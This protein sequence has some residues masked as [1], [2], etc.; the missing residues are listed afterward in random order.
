MADINNTISSSAGWRKTVWG[1]VKDLTVPHEK[2]LKKIQFEARKKLG[3]QYSEVV[4]VSE[5]GGLTYADGSGNVYALND[6]VAA[7]SHEALGSGKEISLKST[8]SF[9]ALSTA[10]SG[11]EQAHGRFFTRWMANAKQSH[12]KRQC[13]VLINGGRHRGSIAVGG[14]AGTGATQTLTLTISETAMGFFLNNRGYIDIYDSTGVTKRNATG[15][16]KIDSFVPG[17]AS[18]TMVV[19][20]TQAS[21]LDAVTDNDIIFPMG[22]K[23]VESPGVLFVA[24]NVSASYLGIDAS[25]IPEWRGNVQAVGGNLSL[26]AVRTGLTRAMD[27]GAMGRFLFLCNSTNFNHFAA[28]IEALR[29]VHRADDEK[30]FKSGL[31]DLEYYI[32]DDVSVMF[33]TSTLMPGGYAVA[34]PVEECYR[35]GSSD[36]GFTLA[37]SGIEGDMIQY[38]EGFNAVQ[39]RTFSDELYWT[40]DPRGHVQFTTIS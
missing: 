16:F 38:L 11:G 28:D 17:T 32:E 33:M 1:D 22:A 5:E 29:Q 20:A 23:G 2:P 13:D 31:M 3:S 26:T 19:T 34:L 4:F 39:L 8:V 36:F 21:E 7:V 40:C 30:H 14:A 37:G 25:A 6:S 9:K 18:H 35:V 12:I 24:G 27:R 10:V 15:T